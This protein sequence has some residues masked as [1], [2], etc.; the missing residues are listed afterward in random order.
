MLTETPAERYFKLSKPRKTPNRASFMNP[1]GVADFRIGMTVVSH[2]CTEMQR[3]VEVL[4]FQKRKELQK[5]IGCVPGYI[6]LH[7]TGIGR[8]CIIIQQRESCTNERSVTGKPVVAKCL[9]SG[10][11]IPLLFQNVPALTAQ[12]SVLNIPN[13]SSA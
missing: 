12:S 3:F 13:S 10:N 8:V 2:E 6:G 1:D 7:P 11:C 9:K 4:L 5:Q